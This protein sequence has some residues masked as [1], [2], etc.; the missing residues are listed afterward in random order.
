MKCILLINLGASVGT[1]AI[2]RYIELFNHL[3][4]T[5]NDILLILNID[6]YNN[7]KKFNILNDTEK[8]IVLNIATKRKS[9]ILK[10]HSIKNS[11]TQSNGKINYLNNLK[12]FLGTYKYFFKL[13]IKW[14]QFS[15]YFLLITK[16]YKIDTIYSVFTG[17]IWVWPIAKLLK[18][19]LIFSSNSYSF[20]DTYTSKIKISLDVVARIRY[21]YAH[22]CF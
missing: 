2:R 15:Y 14:L 16:K 11:I 22:Q 19:K 12:I 21:F 10:S 1:G 6:L 8:V 13:L 17:G 3:S 9:T 20:A 7:L 5:S 4:K 18:V